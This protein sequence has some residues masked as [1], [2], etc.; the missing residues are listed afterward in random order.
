MKNRNA[1][2]CVAILMVGIAALCIF[3][4]VVLTVP[5]GN[6][7]NTSIPS[8]DIVVNNPS[9]VT[10]DERSDDMLSSDDLSSFGESSSEPIEQ[11]VLPPNAT[12]NSQIAVVYDVALGHNIYALNEDAVTA[13]ASL[14]KLVTALVALE[15]LP[16]S[17]TLTVGE[18]INRVGE[19]SSI[20]FLSVGQRYTV[21]TLIDALLI[22]SGNDAAY[23]LA[24]NT[25]R[26]VANNSSLSVDN[27][28]SDFVRLMNDKVKS[29][30]CTSTYFCTPDGYDADGQETT[31]NDMVII[32]LAALKNTTIASSVSKE[33][34]GAWTNSNSLVCTESSYY[35]ECVTG[36]KTG[37][38]GAAGYCVAVSATVDEK[39][40]IM[41][42]LNCT[43]RD[44]RFADANT[45][46]DII[47]SLN[48][49]DSLAA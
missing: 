44:G 40:Y 20:A 32:S 24:V 11:L 35:N 25:A 33:K 6:G 19:N 48:T 42:F 13:P 37:S 9:D 1:I 36:L 21:K 3:G 43:T 29:L 30:G 2:I 38:T 4:A 27:A 39:Q 23:V 28:I 12:L 46:I 31:A 15:H 34:S 49:D 14:T 16:A 7:N 45:F 26:S 17:K 47:Q 5:S 10:S 41:I 22:P 18:E 8:N